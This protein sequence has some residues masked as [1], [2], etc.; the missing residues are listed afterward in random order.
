MGFFIVQVILLTEFKSKIWKFLDIKDRI[1]G[2]IEYFW[3]G[4][5]LI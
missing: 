2:S 4:D 3:V 5:R 1:L